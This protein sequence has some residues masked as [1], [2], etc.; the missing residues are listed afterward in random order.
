MR[1]FDTHCHYNLEPLF[2]GQPSHF[3]IKPADPILTKNWQRHW[4]TARQKG[5]LG[6][7]VV[8]ADLESSKRALKIN[9]QEPHLL[10]TVGIHPGVVSEVVSH[11]LAD[12]PEATGDELTEY[13]GEMFVAQIKILRSLA[14]NSRV[15]AIGETGC[16]YFHFDTQ[17]PFP[18]IQRAAQAQVFIAQIQLANELQLPLIIHVRDRMATAYT[19]ALNL[20]KTHFAFISP[21]ILHCVSGPIEYVKAAV[22]LGGF[23]G[24]DGNLNYKNNHDLLALLEIA[25]IDRIVVETDAPYLP[26]IPYRGQVCEPWM[27]TEVAKHLLSV[28]NITEE[29]LLA[30]TVALF[31]EPVKKLITDQS[32]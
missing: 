29:Q 12:Q 10:P 25:P 17:T 23:I 13:L 2:S 11:F 31:G 8:G 26:P 7:L 20:L 21:F 4:E 19:D 28:K 15:V 6:G 30:N 18:D 14:E 22:A 24:F 5:V 1:C 27:V 9:T 32:S 16:D 3:R